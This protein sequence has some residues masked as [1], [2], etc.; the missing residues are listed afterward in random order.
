VDV[1]T[2]VFLTSALVGGEWSALRPGRFTPCTY[3]IG[4]WVGPKAGLNDMEKKKF[5]TPP[6]LELPPL[7]RQASSQSLYRLSYPGSRPEILCKL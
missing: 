2:H 7:G 6:G 3:W 1:Q 4:G 5:L